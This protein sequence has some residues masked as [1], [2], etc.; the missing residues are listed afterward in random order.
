[1]RATRT[2]QYSHSE[3]LALEHQSSHS[4][5]LALEH[6]SSHSECVPLGHQSSH[7]ECLALEHQ[8][9]H[10]EC[11]PLGHHSIL[12]EASSL[13]GPI[14]QY[15]TGHTP[16]NWLNGVFVGRV[17]RLSKTIHVRLCLGY[18]TCS[19]FRLALIF[20]K[21]CYKKRSLCHFHFQIVKV[22]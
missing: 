13:H 1:M 21:H 22:S 12:T 7:S 18:G 4:E 16:I 20:L 9:S 2:S 17:V 5:C 6:Q 15:S 8:S 14:H 10:S 11:V 19:L 3:C